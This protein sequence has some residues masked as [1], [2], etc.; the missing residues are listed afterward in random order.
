MAPGAM[1]LPGGKLWNLACVGI[2][3]CRGPFFLVQS[4]I[5]LVTCTSFTAFT[6]ARVYRLE[7]RHDIFSSRNIHNIYNTNGNDEIN[8]TNNNEVTIGRCGEE[9]NGTVPK[10]IPSTAE[11]I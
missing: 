5:S 1:T 7:N 6:P 11:R 2:F 3:F 9:A 4:V 10:W 8:C